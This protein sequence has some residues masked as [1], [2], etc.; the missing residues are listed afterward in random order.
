M[1]KFPRDT[2]NEMRAKPHAK[3]RLEHS[4]H[5]VKQL[6]FHFAPHQIQCV[7]E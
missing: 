3:R 4:F 7:L 2:N 1:K 5:I 6:P